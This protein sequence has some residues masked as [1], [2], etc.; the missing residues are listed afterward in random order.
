VIVFRRGHAAG[1]RRRDEG[2]FTLPELLASVCIMG[3]VVTPLAPAMTQALKF[4]P[5]SSARTKAAT[6]SER[7]LREFSNDIASANM[8]PNAGRVRNIPAAKW[9]AGSGPSIAC[10]TNL[11]ATPLIWAFWRDQG[12]GAGANPPQMSSIYSL[13]W[14]AAAGGFV[15]AEVWRQGVTTNERL[16]VG[17]CRNTASGGLPVDSN[18]AKVTITP[19]TS[20]TREQVE[21]QLRLRTRPDLP[22]TELTLSGAVRAS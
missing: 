9:D 19:P 18:V 14:F 1:V 22:P 21:I 12:L 20:T 11:A 15:R 16:L 6:D 2:G 3:L 7:L 4:V 13:K 8:V 17:Y 10:P 5:E